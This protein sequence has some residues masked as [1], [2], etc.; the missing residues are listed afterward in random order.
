MC[1]PGRLTPKAIPLDFVREWL[2]SGSRTPIATLATWLGMVNVVNASMVKS[3]WLAGE[4]LYSLPQTQVVFFLRI[5]ESSGE[6]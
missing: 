2:E 3:T 4:G 5:W 6:R 1:L